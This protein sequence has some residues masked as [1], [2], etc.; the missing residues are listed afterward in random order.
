MEG[1][2]NNNISQKNCEVYQK[3]IQKGSRYKD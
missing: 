1:N 2:G 3:Y